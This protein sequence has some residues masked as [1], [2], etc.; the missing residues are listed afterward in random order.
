VRARLAALT[1]R[2]RASLFLV[3]TLFVVSAIVLAQAT[4]AVDDALGSG[5][6]ELPLGLTSTVES[7]RAVLSSIAGATITVAGI[8]FSVSI[9]TIQLASSQYSPRVVTGL[10]RDPFNKRVMGAVVGTF[11]YC[12]IVMRSVRSPIEQQGDPVVPN[13]SVGLGV[14]FGI[15]AVLA[16]IAFIN[17]NAHA[18][19]ISEILTVVTRAATRAVEAQGPIPADLDPWPLQEADELPSGPAA[20]IGFDRDGWVQLVDHRALLAVAPEGGTVRLETAAGRYAIVGSPLCTVW[21]PPEDE[22]DA[23][24]RA[25]RAVRLGATRTIAHDPSFG[26]RQLADVA[27]KALSP[28]VNDPTTA[29]DAIFHLSAVLRAALDRDEPARGLYHGDRRLVLESTV[30]HAELLDLGFSE[31]RHFGAAQPAVCLYALEALAL[32]ERS[33]APA[34]QV[35]AGPEIRR[36]ADLIVRACE[37]AEPS[38]VELAAVRAYHG[39]HFVA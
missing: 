23:A 10:F 31:I 12:L 33:L 6:T 1:E 26:V 34:R 8:A 36:Q 30:G 37:R 2:L 21:P 22:G 4:L 11:T 9:L 32:V 17:H 35:A 28:G 38:Q 13:V 19:D 27:V 16:T 5:A 29:Q 7:A 14:V 39:E 3:P 25:R 18:I 24:R 20:R 15:A